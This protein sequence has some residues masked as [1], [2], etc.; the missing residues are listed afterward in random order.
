MRLGHDRRRCRLHE[1]SVDNR[2]G[3]LPHHRWS[4][5]KHARPG[6]AYAWHVVMAA[7]VVGVALI[8]LVAVIVNVDTSVIAMMVMLECRD[9]RGS[10]R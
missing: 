10:V 3:D 1:R 9:R 7:I 6:C 4:A 8:T 2:C 5:R